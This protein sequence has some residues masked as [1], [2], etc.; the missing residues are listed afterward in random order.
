MRREP[1]GRVKGMGGRMAGCMRWERGGSAD[2][3]NRT[4]VALEST[5]MGERVIE[6]RRAEG[7]Q[8]SSSSESYGD[9]RAAKGLG[10]AKRE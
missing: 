6:H 7:E 3:R 10:E 4:W 9:S 8:G 2:S 5:R 1:F